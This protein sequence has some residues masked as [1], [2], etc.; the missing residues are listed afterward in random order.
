M[1]EEQ[2]IFDLTEDHQSNRRHCKTPQST[3]STKTCDFLKKKEKR[4]HW[5][6]EQHTQV[7]TQVSQ[8]KK[9]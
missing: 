6:T 8:R 7:E 9:K 1:G 3:A 5:C 2:A 4:K